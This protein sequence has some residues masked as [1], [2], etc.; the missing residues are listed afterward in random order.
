MTGESHPVAKNANASF[1]VEDEAGVGDRINIAYSS[2]TVSKGRAIAVVASTG[3]HTEI[4]KIAQSLRGDKSKVRK[5]RR[6][7]EGNAPWHR[8]FEA[9]ALTAKD[10]VGKFLG[11]SVG[12]PLQRKLSWLAIFLFLIAVVF[13]I[14]CLAANKFSSR[15]EVILYAVGYV[16]I[17][18]M[19]QNPQSLST[20]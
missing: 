7:D 20:G 15:K 10:G 19:V 3:M 16:A 6:D 1:T 4:G 18:V 5:V 13:A 12:T 2:S 14:I 9:A 11:V 8:Y 17:G